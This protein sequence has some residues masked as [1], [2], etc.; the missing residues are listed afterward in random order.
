MRLHHDGPLTVSFH[1]G[2]FVVPDV[3]PG[4]DF[5]VP[6]ELAPAFLQHG[7]VREVKKAPSKKAPEHNP[8]VNP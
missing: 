6:D 3:E 4:A 5:E 1:V 8:D 2:E 7:H